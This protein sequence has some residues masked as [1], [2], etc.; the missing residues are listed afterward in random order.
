M[1][2]SSKIFLPYSLCTSRF[3]KNREGFVGC[4]YHK[5]AGVVAGGMDGHIRKEAQP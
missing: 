3:E 4:K 5:N 2:F 1:L